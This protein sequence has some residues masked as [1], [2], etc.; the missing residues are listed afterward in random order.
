[1]YIDCQV[2]NKFFLKKFKKLMND[3]MAYMQI[4]NSKINDIFGLP[5]LN[6][7]VI[8]NSIVCLNVM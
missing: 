1:M 5:E 8:N 4:V 2:H 3:N 7:A 6:K